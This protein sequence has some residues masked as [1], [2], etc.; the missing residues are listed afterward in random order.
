MAQ[1]NILLPRERY[2]NL[3]KKI[4]RYESS[5]KSHAQPPLEE[6]KNEVKKK[7]DEVKEI[8][9]FK[10][11]KTGVMAKK[12]KT[13]ENKPQQTTANKNEAHKRKINSQKDVIKEVMESEHPPY[14]IA[15]PGIPAMSQARKWIRF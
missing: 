2:E 9:E 3:L 4:E 5:D 12:K 8:D 13:N 1:E 10:A 6:I 7:I 11:E 15:P 14:R